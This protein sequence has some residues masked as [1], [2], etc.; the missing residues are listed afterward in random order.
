MEGRDTALLVYLPTG[1]GAVG[2]PCGDTLW[3]RE[4]RSPFRVPEICLLLAQLSECS[5]RKGN[6]SG[7]H[8]CQ[9]PKAQER[10]GAGVKGRWQGGVVTP[11]PAEVSPGSPAQRG[12]EEPG[13]GAGP[14]GGCRPSTDKGAKSLPAPSKH[15]A[16]RRV[17]L[18]QLPA[19]RAKNGTRG[20]DI[21]PGKNDPFLFPSG[22]SQAQCVRAWVPG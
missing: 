14:Q 10:Q 3:T 18:G 5:R 4:N 12:R 21:C 9:C 6:G 1:K 19:G 16:P 22:G 13:G 17:A 2:I 15:L 11:Q 7:P 8:D 20:G